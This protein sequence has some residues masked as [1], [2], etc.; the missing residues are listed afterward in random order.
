MEAGMGKLMKSLT[1]SLG[2]LL[3]FSL[4]GLPFIILGLFEV[5]KTASMLSR[6]SR[7]EGVVVENVW[8]SFA[9]GAAYSPRVEFQAADGLSTRFTDGVG[10]IP[11]DYAVGEKVVVLYDPQGV[12]APRIQSWMRIWLAPLMFIGAGMV[13]VVAGI[14]GYSVINST[15]RP[16]KNKK[17]G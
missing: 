13:P 16:Q 10:T 6:F 12:E 1:G 9:E 17:R 2:M 3:V 14:I 15:L 11:A 8:Q 5:G 4:A 7:A